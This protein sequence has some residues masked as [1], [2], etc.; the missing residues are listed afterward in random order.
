[1]VGS[2]G[3]CSPLV[4]WGAPCGCWCWAIL[5]IGRGGGGPCSPLVWGCGRPCSPLVGGRDGPCSSFIGNHHRR[6][7]RPLSLVVVPCPSSSSWSLVVSLHRLCLFVGAG[8]CLWA[9]VGGG[10]GP[11]FV[12]WGWRPFLCVGRRS[13][14]FWGVCRHFWAVIFD[15]GLLA[16]TW[17]Q[18]GHWSSLGASLVWW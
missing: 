4:G 9:V 5:T 1:M 18:G 7:C 3:W 12:F 17:W 13:C 6:R 2:G 10:G 16:S 14:S 8:H 11:W 15:G